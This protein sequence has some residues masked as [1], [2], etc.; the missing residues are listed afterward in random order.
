MKKSTIHFIRHGQT[1]YNLERRIQGS[2]DI[3][4]SK[5]GVKQAETIPSEKFLSHYDIS[6][7]S[8]LSRSQKTLEIILDSN[9]INVEKK[10]SKLITERAYGCF[11][12]LQDNVIRSKYPNHYE[13][14]KSNEN[15]EIEGAETIESVVNRINS[16]I[17]NMIIDNHQNILAV[18]HS[19][20]LYALYKYITKT[21]LG[22]RPENIKFPNCCSVYLDI[23]HTNKVIN[24]L[25]LH[26]QDQTY[27]Y[28]SGP[29]EMVVAT[30]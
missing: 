20:V 25:E 11:E 28:C 1:L 14:W 26:I 3:E 18:T 4:L 23:Y 9:K 6:Y 30:S 16:F 7:Y 17:K 21:D 19:G 13:S 22:F 8:P 24:R 5:L 10:L 12:G 27:V 29:T 15:T 2:I